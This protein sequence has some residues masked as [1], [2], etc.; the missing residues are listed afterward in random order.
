MIPK[1]FLALWI[2][3]AGLLFSASHVAE[4]AE[5]SDGQAPYFSTEVKITVDPLRSF[6]L[7]VGS[8]WTYQVTEWQGTATVGEAYRYDYKTIVTVLSHHHTDQGLVIV[9]RRRNEDVQV[10][11]SGPKTQGSGE[12]K[13][14]KADLESKETFDNYLVRGS[15][16]YELPDWAW[17]VKKEQFTL[18][19][20]SFFG[21]LQKKDFDGNG[22]VPEF[23]FPMRVWTI[24]ADWQRERE[25]LKNCDEAFKTGAKGYCAPL[26][27]YWIVT[28]QED[29]SVP[30]GK[31][32]GTYALEYPTVGGVYRRWF[33]EGVGVE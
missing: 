20:K 19:V 7:Q 22:I 8:R 30:F 25:D 10:S 13:R 27:S 4:A 23:F 21:R 3:L 12:L 28:A 31:V 18:A 32:H 16:V 5:E 9:R 6:P 14:R 2:F 11:Y 17:D 15:Y 1:Y 33:K 26:S 29:V 24:W